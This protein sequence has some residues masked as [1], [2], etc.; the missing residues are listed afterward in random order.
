MKDINQKIDKIIEKQDEAAKERG[1]TKTNIA[2]IRNDLNHHIKRTDIL[3]KE[4]KPIVI[5]FH[6]FGG[7]IATMGG[8]GVA[9]GIILGLIN[10]YSKLM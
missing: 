9:M 7:I 8:L 5:Y 2:V 10:L 6:K 1:E 3:E 4:M